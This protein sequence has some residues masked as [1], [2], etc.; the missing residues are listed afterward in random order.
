MI[1]Y[2]GLLEVVR[3]ESRHFTV[4]T[5]HFFQR[6]FKNDVVDFEE[7]MNERVIGVL[8]ILA[9]FSGLLSFG[10]FSKYN[11]VPD[12]GISWIEKC[13]FITYCMLIMGFLAVLEW[14]VL[15]PDSRDYANL[16]PLPIRARTLLAA[17]FAS[18]CLFGGMFGL[19]L[20]SLATLPCVL[21]LPHWHS[22]SVLYAVRFALVHITSLF[23]ACFFAFFFSVLLIGIF[24]AFLGHRLFNRISTFIRSFFLVVYVF[25]FLLYMRG[26]FS[27]F[28][29][30][31]PLE[32]LKN[33]DLFLKY[34]YDLF[35]PLWFTDLYETLLGNTNIP[36]HGTY[37]YALFGLILMVGAFYL[38]TGLS[39]RRYLKNLSAKQVGRIHFRKLR[40]FFTHIFDW[41]FLRNPVQ[42]AIFHFYGKTLK[43]SM[44]HRMQ[45][46]SFVAVGVGLIPFQIAISDVG[47]KGLFSINKIMLSIPLILSFFLLLG[48][49]EV[50]NMPISIG[51]NWIFQLTE[52]RNIRHY[53]SALRKGIFFFNLL[54]LFV[55]L[56]ICYFFLWDGMT[57]SYHCLYGLAVSVLVME[58]FFL[59]YCKIP[60]ACTYLPGKEKIHLFWL[61]YLVLVLAYINIMSWIE[62]TLLRVPLN[63][64]IFYG[65]VFF[66]ILGIRI[67]QLFFFYR[68]IGIVYEEELEPVMIGLDYRA[69]Y[70][71]R[72]IT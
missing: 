47:P 17:K 41:A 61:F 46:A 37:N 25:I 57:A 48:L 72:R 32:K 8:V 39:Y 27:G 58:I 44:F 38:T 55:G 19:S 26:L 71:K 21:F 67:Y 68:H 7:Q 24:M 20:N 34:F 9:V 15:F 16:Y 62:S 6:L 33:S 51:A 28:D 31:I 50:V 2:A 11:L 13:G 43:S 18:L 35:P 64:F 23:L 69:P 1:A 52:R 53:F 42:R 49:R 12:T 4:L 10:F 65:I 3:K 56:F 5:R 45:L 54:P 40:T 60:F 36:F 66:I 29:N 22:S 70:N 59:S 14:D 63:F 30:V